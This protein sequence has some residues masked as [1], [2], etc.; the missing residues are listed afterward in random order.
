MNPLMELVM[1][2]LMTAF[3]S[4]QG[5]NCVSNL[6]PLAPSVQPVV[7]TRCENPILN[8]WLDMT[9]AS[10]GNVSVRFGLLT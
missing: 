1:A 9:I 8:S 4:V 2:V 6:E 3:G 5:Y 7:V 10:D